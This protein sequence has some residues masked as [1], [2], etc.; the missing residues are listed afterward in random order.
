MEFP[1]LTQKVMEAQ[2]EYIKELEVE[3]AYLR[4]EKKKT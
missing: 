2:A 1:L 3:L 4:G